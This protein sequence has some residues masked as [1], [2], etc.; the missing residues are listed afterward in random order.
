MAARLAVLSSDTLCP[1]KAMTLQEQIDKFLSAS[2][3]AVV[4]A[5][6]DANKYGYKCYRCYLDDG[7]KVFAVNPNAKTVLGNPAFAD[8]SSLPEIVESVT[9]VTPPA[10]TAR[11]VDQAIAKGI[12]NIWMQP[13]AEHQEAI[14]K[15]RANGLNVISGGPCILVT[16]GYHGP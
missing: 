3:Y 14:E 6:D 13:G 2:A 7:R 8:L 15:A 10:V 12:P 4:G 11:V 16:L 9:I 5:S 1:M